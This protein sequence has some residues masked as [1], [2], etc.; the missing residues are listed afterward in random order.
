MPT[1]REIYDALDLPTLERWVKEQQQEDLHLDFKRV[2]GR[3]SLNKEDRANLSEAVAGFANSDGGLL[4]WG[5]D[6]R[7][8]PGEAV[9][10]A[11]AL[12]PIEDVAAVL[13]QLRDNPKQVTTPVVDGV[14][15]RIIDGLT[16]K[17][18]YIATLV[19]PSDRGPHMASDNRYYKRNGASF[20]KMEHFD[21]AD[22]FGRRQRSDLRLHLGYTRVPG[23]EPEQRVFKLQAKIRNHGRARA[24]DFKVEFYFPKTLIS[25]GEIVPYSD[26]FNYVFFQTQAALFPDDERPTSFNGITYTVTPNLVDYYRSKG[27]PDVEFRIFQDDL[28]PTTAWI[29]LLDLTDYQKRPPLKG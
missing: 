19:P 26:L 23:G 3:T 12:V 8:G 5:I 29:S 25:S 9:D 21:V 13:S 17:T 11:Q 7:K 2:S 14:E 24:H 10:G 18:G 15:H 6:A 27:W 20:H 16:E 22:M 1:T 4:V 28:A